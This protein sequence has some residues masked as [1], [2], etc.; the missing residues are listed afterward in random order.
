MVW[1]QHDEV[2]LDAGLVAALNLAQ[3]NLH[4]L[5]VQRRLVAHAPAQVDGLE[6]RIVLLAQL[7]QPGEDV[8]LQSVTLGLQV[9]KG[10]TDKNPG[11]SHA[12]LP[13]FALD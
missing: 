2:G 9:F 5:L 4:G 11:L 1:E 8:A 12:T 10:R 6:A 13:G 7:A 3:A